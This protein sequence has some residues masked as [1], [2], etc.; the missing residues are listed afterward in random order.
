MPGTTAL[1]I[2]HEQKNVMQ[3]ATLSWIGQAAT[4]CLFFASVASDLALCFSAI[5]AALLLSVSAVV[6]LTV[7]TAD[8]SR[9]LSLRNLFA[10]DVARARDCGTE[11]AL[12]EVEAIFRESWVTK[13]K[14][15]AALSRSGSLSLVGAAGFIVAIWCSVNLAAACLG[16][17]LR[18][19]VAFALSWLEVFAGR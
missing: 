8:H 15:D 18:P 14:L 2:A 10:A 11:A 19:E 3:I 1:T 4:T 12:Q 16:L 6:S 13:N 7:G 17:Y 5:T 9:D